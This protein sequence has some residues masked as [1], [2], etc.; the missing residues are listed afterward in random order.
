MKKI[1]E[2]DLQDVIILKPAE[3]NKIH[4]GGNHTPL[5]PEQIKKLADEANRQ[6]PEKNELKRHS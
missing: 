3:L 1:P 5:S 4:F 6:G 2:P